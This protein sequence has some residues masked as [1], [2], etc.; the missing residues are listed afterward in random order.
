MGGVKHSQ[1]GPQKV[2]VLTIKAWGHLVVGLFDNL[3]SLFL[4]LFLWQ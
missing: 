4:H 3:V 2:V 1:N